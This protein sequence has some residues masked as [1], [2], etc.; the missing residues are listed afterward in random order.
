MTCLAV[1]LLALAA[2]QTAWATDAFCTVDCNADGTVNINELI[3]GTN[4]GLGTAS[5]AT[6]ERADR[7]QNGAVSI[8]ELITGVSKALMG[9]ALLDLQVSVHNTSAATIT[10]SGTRLSG[11]A[12][13]AR[14][15]TSYVRTFT[16]VTAS[17]GGGTPCPC[18]SDAPCR[19]PDLAPGLWLHRICVDTSGGTCSVT[20]HQQQARRSL[21]SEDVTMPAQVGW[22]AFRTVLNVSSTGDSGSGT[23][24]AALASAATA[25]G[26]LLVQFRRDIFPA[27]TLR[28]IEVTHATETLVIRGDRVEIDATDLDGHPSPVDPW[29]AR[30]YYR[31]LELTSAAAP[32]GGALAFGSGTSDAVEQA[33]VIGLAITRELGTQTTDQDLVIF[34][35]G[36]DTRLNRLDTCLLD[37]GAANFSSGAAGI[38]CIDA[39]DVSQID[40]EANTI[41]N[42]EIRHC[43]DRGIK[44][45]RGFLKVEDS[46]IH[47]N[48]RGGMFVQNGLSVS[49]QVTPAPTPPAGAGMLLSRRN[50]IERNGRN[51]SGQI[52][53][54]DA[55]QVATQES[56]VATRIMQ[57]TSEGDLI[58][59]GVEGGITV[60]EYARTAV[61]GTTVCGMTGRQD[62]VLTGG[63]GIQATV[64]A[65][66][67]EIKVRG[68]T[69]VYNNRNG[70]L[71]AGTYH[72]NLDFGRASSHVNGIGNNAFTQNA[73]VHPEPTPGTPHNFR[74]TTSTTNAVVARGNQWQRCGEQSVCSSAIQYDTDPIDRVER[75]PAQ[76]H[77]ANDPAQ[78]PFRVTDVSPKQVRPG[79]LLRIHGSGFNAIEGYPQGGDCTTAPAANNRCD[80]LSGTCIE[81]EVAPGNWM[82]LHTVQSVTPTT[83]T[84]KWPGS[85]FACDAPMNIRA[86]RLGPAGAGGEVLPATSRTKLLCVN[87]TATLD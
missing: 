34:R 25:A 5:L 26:P 9:C 54:D 51:S 16:G 18:P 53:F 28:T 55:R 72:T 2:Q 22:T 64:N 24:R 76:P 43:R 20:T 59:D 12:L 38:D 61:T 10:L 52:T 19:V 44:A 33:R 37:G 14:E 3:R 63:Q 82:P 36:S 79:Q 32:S 80:T 56:G 13:G 31:V 49:G 4:I 67:Q 75:A 1:T 70:V 78:Y 77:R 84:L 68:S 40:V 27:G 71:L 60:R 86:R 48:L 6:C 58:R 17:C 7:N 8:D 83:I 65:G 57:L 42:S 29:D 15:A 69:S 41:R 62:M 50:L 47:K 39:M 74:N 11:P 85:G 81:V 87:D 45:E 35:G 66:N 30:Q 46:W 73:L 21:I 23:L